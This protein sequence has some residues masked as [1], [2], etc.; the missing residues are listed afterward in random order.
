M[1]HLSPDAKHHIL[2]EYSP[3]DR[4]RGFTAI[5]HRHEIKGGRQTLHN[6]YQRWDGTAASLLEEKKTGR[7]RILSRAEVSRHIRA[8]ILAANRSHHAI[9]YT[10]ILPSLQAK[11][12]TDVSIQTI[13]RYGKEEL[14]VKQRHTRKRTADE[15]KCTHTYRRGIE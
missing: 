2:L 4:T 8:P 11:T 9:H 13:R 5:A 1:S 12:H 3:H 14:G 7:P 6:W 15:S 10:D